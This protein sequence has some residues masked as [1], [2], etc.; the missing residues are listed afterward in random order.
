MENSFDRCIDFVIKWESSCTND[1]NDRGGETCFG[2]SKRAYPDLE[3]KSLT[4]EQAKNIYKND[5]WIKCRCDDLPEFMRLSVFDCAVN[6]GISRAIKLL[7]KSIGVESDS[8]VGPKTIAACSAIDENAFVC[9]YNINRIL[10]YVKLDGFD[11]F[12]K[13]WVNRVID[14]MITERKRT[15]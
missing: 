14:I 13:G 9:R 5:Y 3:I 8:V 15:V 2:I 1:H 4:L 11:R 7:Q 6:M 12:G 10:H